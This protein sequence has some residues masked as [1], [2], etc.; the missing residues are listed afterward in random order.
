MFTQIFFCF[1][2]FCRKQLYIKKRENGGK[3]DDT[4]KKLQNCT[5]EDYITFFQTSEETEARKKKKKTHL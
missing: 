5:M 4:S 2:I 1:P 3:T